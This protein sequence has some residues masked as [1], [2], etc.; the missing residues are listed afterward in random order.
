V[1]GYD[2]NDVDED[3]PTSPELPQARR[4]A[5]AVSRRLAV[6]CPAGALGFDT[7]ERPTAAQYQLLRALGFRFACRYLGDL[8]SAEVDDALDAGVGIIPVQHAHLPGWSPDT[9]KGADDGARAVHHAAVAGLPA[10]TLWADIEGC[11]GSAADLAGYVR[12]WCASPVKAGFEAGGYIGSG[13]PGDSETLWRLDFT[14][15]WKSQSDVPTPARRGWRLIQLFAPPYGSCTV[16]D[17][18]PGCS[19]AVRELT[20]DVD[21][22]QSD[23]LGALP[24]MIVRAP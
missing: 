9:L 3:R 12:A 13:T 8:T 7:D 24:K 5:R 18:F 20:I 2:R 1:S 15:Y 19:P 11:A 17:V 10:C 23:Y 21:V 22:A 16:G 14:G 4:R 6:P